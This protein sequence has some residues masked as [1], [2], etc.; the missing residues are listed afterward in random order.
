MVLLISTLL[1][2]FSHMITVIQTESKPK[3]A[4]V[5]GWVFFFFFFFF[6]LVVKLVITF[7]LLQTMLFNGKNVT[8]GACVVVNSEVQA[9]IRAGVD[10]CSFGSAQ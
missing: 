1:V 5:V 9:K 6:F 10:W 3:A 4:S 2:F 8:L 7:V